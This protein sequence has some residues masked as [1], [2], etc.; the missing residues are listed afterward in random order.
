MQL[1]WMCWCR[2]ARSTMMPAVTFLQMASSWQLSSPAARGAFPMKASWQCTPWPPITWAKCS[3][4]S[5]LVRDRKP[6]LMTEGRWCLGMVIARWGTAWVGVMVTYCPYLH[7]GTGQRK[8]ALQECWLVTLQKHLSIR[9]LPHA[10]VTTVRNK[11]GDGC[12]THMHC[13]TVWHCVFKTSQSVS[14]LWQSSF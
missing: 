2:T 8:I 7:W 6:N 13:K 3:T 11:G 12:S 5:D 14:A 9:V 10:P 4:P 1:P